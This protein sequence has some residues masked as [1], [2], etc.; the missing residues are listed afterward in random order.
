MTVSCAAE[1]AVHTVVIAPIEEPKRVVRHRDPLPAETAT[2]AGCGHEI[3]LRVGRVSLPNETVHRVLDDAREPLKVALCDCMHSASG[4]V[5]ITPSR[6]MIEVSGIPE[7][8]IECMRARLV[9]PAFAPWN[10]EG[11][12]PTCGMEVTVFPGAPAR[13]LD[14]DG[15]L[16]ASL[17]FE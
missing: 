6:G 2:P 17:R 5:A 14:P 4:L 13:T 7:E 3:R 8:Q 11:A 15:T 1:P 10:F 16:F 12:C 9:P